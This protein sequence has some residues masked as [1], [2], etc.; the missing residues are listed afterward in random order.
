MWHLSRGNTS[1]EPPPSFK[2]NRHAVGVTCTEV[3][4]LSKQGRHW[5]YCRKSKSVA[6]QVIEDAFSSPDIVP[7]PCTSQ[8]WAECSQNPTNPPFWYLGDLGWI[9]WDWICLRSQGSPWHLSPCR[10]AWWSWWN[11]PENT[12]SSIVLCFGQPF[13]NN[14]V[15]FGNATSTRIYPVFFLFYF[16][17][18][19]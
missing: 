14:S 8:W 9:I 5:L 17:L 12:D 2:L 19:L 3:R 13:I 10:H 11:I 7:L 4:K 6:C 15:I 16:V 18:F 1:S